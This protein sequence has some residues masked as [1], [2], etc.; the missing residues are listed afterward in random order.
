MATA[1]STAKTP[2]SSLSSA[3][4]KQKLS[5]AIDPA[6]ILNRPIDVIAFASDASFYRLIPEAVIQPRG[7][8]EAP[9]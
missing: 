5:A 9:R 8:Q 7:V 3:E 4:L 2:R 6:R 1:A